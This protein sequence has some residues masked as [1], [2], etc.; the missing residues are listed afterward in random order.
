MDNIH[1][2]TLI[3][4]ILQNPKIF[5]TIIYL[6]SIS[7]STPQPTKSATTFDL[8]TSATFLLIILL[9]FRK[10]ET[11]NPFIENLATISNVDTIRVPFT[12][13]EPSNSFLSKDLFLLIY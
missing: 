9:N 6:L 10:Y 8:T 13:L 1:Q 7:T 12:S 11:K 3:E 4:Y 5:K 2:N